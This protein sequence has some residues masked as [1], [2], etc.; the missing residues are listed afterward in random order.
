[1]EPSNAAGTEFSRK[2]LGMEKRLLLAAL[3]FVGLGLA[4]CGGG[5]KGGPTDDDPLGRLT[6]QKN[7]LMKEGILAEVAV[8]KSK[9]L[10][11]GINKVELETRGKMTRSIEAKTSTLQKQFKEEVGPEFLDHF[12]QVSK[13]VASTVLSGTTLIETPYREKKGEYEVYG[14]MVLDAKAFKD[15]IAAQL[16]ANE[17]MKT[18]WLASKA[19]EELQKEADAFD[20]F[21]RDMQG[22]T[23]NVGGKSQ[24]ES[25]VKPE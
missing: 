17:A 4:G 6:A 16:A 18:R 12:S 5:F 8:A 21:K 24:A 19:Y 20:R 2:D 23:G 15:A 1:M 22:P 3:A 11:T 25:A 7:K 14:L 13:S 10:Q 9:D